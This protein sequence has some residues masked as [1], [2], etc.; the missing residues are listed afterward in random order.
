MQENYLAKWLNNELS[1]TELEAFEKSDEYT[2]YKKIA[3]VSSTLEAPEFDVEKALAESKLGR[4]TSK[5]KVIKLNPFK[6]FTSIAAAIV[7]FIAGAYFFINTNEQ[8]E[9]ALAQT[10]L[11]TLPDA[12]EVVLNADS[13]IEYSIK[14]W[15]KKRHLTLNG[16]A[17]FKV[18]KGKKF[19]VETSAGTIQVLGTQ[20]N[21]TNRP[22]YFK[23]TCFE[24]L[25]SVTH[26]N[27]T[28]K[29]PAGTSFLVLN[30]QI[31]STEAPKTNKPSWIDNESTFTSIPLTFVLAELERQYNIS[32]ISNTIDTNTLFTGTFTN[33]NIDS[34]LKSI[35]VPNNITYAL[36]GN[37][38]I[39][40]AKNAE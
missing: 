10:E 17:Y 4:T 35:C 34:A 37:K 14:N 21:I 5:G 22:N 40:H 28:I 20:F 19:T 16:E 23:V 26:K 8:I 36:E 29:L 30:D 31:I 2:A 39:L 7:L 1:D 3:S 18:A 27:E 9:T 33:K 13:K 38:V 11:I 32:I 6:K 25:V 24:G 15:D 12:S